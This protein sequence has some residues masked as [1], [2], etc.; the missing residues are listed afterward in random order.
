MKS[1]ETRARV[2]APRLGVKRG[3]NASGVRRRFVDPRSA[4]AGPAATALLPVC[5]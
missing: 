5:R 1:R 4:K 2:V 3:A